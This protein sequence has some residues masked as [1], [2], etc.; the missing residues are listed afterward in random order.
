MKVKAFDAS[1]HL[2]TPELQWLYLERCIREDT[3]EGRLIKYAVNAIIKAQ[4]VCKVSEKANL[5]PQELA[6]EFSENANPSM[7]TFLRVV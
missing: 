2:N 6:K 4:G 7:E 1:Q 3:G 5:S